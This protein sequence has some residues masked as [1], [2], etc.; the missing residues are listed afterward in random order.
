MQLPLFAPDSPWRAPRVGDLPSW[1]NA[2]QVSIDVETR[3]P[4]LRDLG[5][6]VRRSPQENY[7]AGFSFALSD[8]KDHSRGYYVPLRHAGGDNVEDPN[9]A[10]EWLRNQAKNFKGDVV[11]MNLSYDLD[12]LAEDGVEFN[13]VNKIRDVMIAETLIYELHFSYSLDAI[14]GRRGL[15]LKDTSMLIEAAKSYGVD[16][17]SEMWKLP[18]RFVGAYGEGDALRPFQ[19]LRLQ[20]KDIEDQ[21]LAQV[22]NLESDLLPVLVRMR[23]RGIRIDQVKL[24]Q[25][26]EWSL[27]EE[28]QCLDFVHDRTGHRI[29]VGDVWKAGA[30][31]PALEEIGLKLGR[32]PKSN[33][34]KIDKFLLEN[35]EHP[36][37]DALA[38]A[39]KVNKL[40]TTFAKSIWHHMVNGRIHTTLVQIAGEDEG[41]GKVRGGRF[42]RMSCENPNLQQQPSRDDF[43]NMWR[44]I[45]IA[46]E[47]AQWCCADISQQEPRWA[48]HFAHKLQLPGASEMVRRYIEEPSTDNHQAMA[49]ITGLERNHA[50]IVGLGIMYG[51]GGYS[52]CEEL[53]LPTRTMVRDPRTREAYDLNT[54]EGQNAL[55]A[56]GQRYRA[57][58]EEGQA[59]LDR[60]DANAPFVR[61]LSKIC[62]KTVKN[63]GFL[64]TVLGRRCRFPTDQDGNYDWTYRALNRLIQGSS[65]DQMKKAMVD[66]DR[67]G[68]YLQLQVHDE[69]DLSI[70]SVEEGR[71]VED[72]IQ[73]AVPASVPFKVDLEIGRSWGEIEKV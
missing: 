7:I 45:Y 39:R 30:I 71:H 33:A 64:R 6:G 49:E 66:V 23:R 61:K 59:I 21:E 5:P 56:G 11:G 36:V 31:A 38:R 19:L 68:H 18:G 65:A 35:T 26:E 2:K 4:Q 20:E 25:I 53:G 70:G 17:K 43:A 34:P 3:D 50:K 12:W 28:K 40:R 37:T 1:G 58:G 15:P 57:A 60:Y 24:Q 27:K 51:K 41:K 9:L 54:L 16:P 63:R 32:T 73:N 10:M 29:R 69:L 52:L 14:L 44:S 72:L 13:S 55:L 47:G 62:Q 22:W 67:A 8:G 42:G 48:A 46:E